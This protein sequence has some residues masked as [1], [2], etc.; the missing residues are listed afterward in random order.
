MMGIEAAP[1]AVM[2]SDR[3]AN[4]WLVMM[5]GLV[6]QSNAWYAFFR[7]PMERFEL[8]TLGVNL[9]LLNWLLR[10]ADRCA[11]TEAGA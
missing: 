10:A 4:F 2:E 11:L 1:V 8:Y 3:Q 9:E 5:L 6:P 7:P